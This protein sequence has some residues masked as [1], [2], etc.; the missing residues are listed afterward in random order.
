MRRTGGSSGN[1]RSVNIPML[2]LTSKRGSFPRTE[3]GTMIIPA[4]QKVVVMYM[5]SDGIPKS[6]VYSN[7]VFGGQ[8]SGL[9]WV[10]L[11][12]YLFLVT[13]TIGKVR[14]AMLLSTGYADVVSS[15]TRNEI[16]NWNIAI[17]KA[18]QDI[19]ENKFESME[20]KHMKWCTSFNR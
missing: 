5:N 4:K 15:A 6:H 19:S 7:P 20:F 18:K 12:D 17:M 13:I 11:L 9:N 8:I 14:I 3:I 1:V 2:L 16:R 10:D